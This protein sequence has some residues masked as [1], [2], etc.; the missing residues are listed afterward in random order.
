LYPGAP[1]SD[2]ITIKV[3]PQRFYVALEKNVFIYH[4]LY[5][6]LKHMFIFHA[7]IKQ[8]RKRNIHTVKNV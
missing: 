5:L 4:G 3:N 2:A 1:A 8:Y 6:F 7:N